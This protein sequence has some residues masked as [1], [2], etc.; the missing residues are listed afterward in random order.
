VWQTQ[1][2]PSLYSVQHTQQACCCEKAAAMAN[3]LSGTSAQW[4]VGTFTKCNV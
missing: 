4:C 2:W 1:L 3:K